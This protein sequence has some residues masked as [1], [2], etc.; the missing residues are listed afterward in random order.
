MKKIKIVYLLLLITIV[1][2]NIT[3]INVFAVSNSPVENP[4]YWVPSVKGDAAL[5]EK[6]GGILGFI[7]VL[8]IAISIIVLM[9]MGIKYMMGSAEEKAANKSAVIPYL[10]GA[11][12][13]F[14]VTTIPNFIYVITESFFAEEEYAWITYDCNSKGHKFD[15]YHDGRCD[16]FEICGFRCNHKNVSWIENT[17][18][19]TRTCNTCYWTCTHQTLSHNEDYHYCS[20]CG[21][22][23]ENH[24]WNPYNPNGR[25]E[26][27]ACDYKC[28]HVDSNG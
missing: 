6:I 4:D 17:I 23:Q 12:M 19:G 11:V 8:G 2:I 10:V 13:V 24:I 20:T 21:G 22:G 28:E 18:N 9:I 5:N 7:Q 25:C 14:A 1:V 15:I 26:I 27:Y 3:S 16:Y